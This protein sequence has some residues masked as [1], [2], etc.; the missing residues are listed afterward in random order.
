M[1]TTDPHAQVPPPPGAAPAPAAAAAPPPAA[2]PLPTPPPPATGGGTHGAGAAHDEPPPPPPRRA[3]VAEIHPAPAKIHP[4]PWARLD[5]P[6]PPGRPVCAPEAPAL[7]VRAGMVDMARTTVRAIGAMPPGGIVVNG[8]VNIVVNG[9]P[10][11]PA[12]R[13]VERAPVGEPPPLARGVRAS[14]QAGSA[15][16][17]GWE[18][19]LLVAAVLAATM[20]LGIWLIKP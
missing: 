8:D 9:R 12:D 19:I 4:A 6:P 13:E 7:P 18:A 20:F 14:F 10:A 15:A 11:A 2:A 1:P 17:P 5:G 16:A 3:T